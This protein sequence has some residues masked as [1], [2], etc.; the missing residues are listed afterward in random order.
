[1]KWKDSYQDNALKEGP[2]EESFDD[3]DVYPP[4]DQETGQKDRKPFGVKGKYSYVIAGLI[5]VVLV[6][7]LFNFLR[8][9]KN[10]SQLEQQLMVMEE[11]LGQIEARLQFVESE[12][13]ALQSGAEL[14]KTVEML[15]RRTVRMEETFSKR[16]EQIDDRLAALSRKTEASARKSKPSTAK[17]VPQ[18]TARFNKKKPSV[19]YH[20]VQAGDTLYGISRKYGVSVNDLMRWNNL[21]SRSILQPGQK[22]KIGS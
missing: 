13:A 20:E 6:M 7:F 5:A 1:M 8:S 11:K 22:L 16:F 9:G 15:S 21:S 10:N 4:F 19:A 3:E 17:S 2:E 12:R 18:K 14:G